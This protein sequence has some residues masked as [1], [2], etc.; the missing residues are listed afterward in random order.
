MAPA[1]ALAAALVKAQAWVAAALVEAQAWG[2]SEAQDSQAQQ[3][4]G[5]A[6]ESEQGYL[7]MS[8]SAAS[9]QVVADVDLPAAV[10]QS[11]AR[12]RSAWG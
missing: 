10:A 12:V 4:W 3:A 2:E 7:A 8:A 9:V 11:H 6:H 5:Q 1:L